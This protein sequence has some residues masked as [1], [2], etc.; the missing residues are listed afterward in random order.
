[1]TFY[2][3]HLVV[4]VILRIQCIIYDNVVSFCSQVK[5]LIILCCVTE[6][7]VDAIGV[8]IHS[9]CTRNQRN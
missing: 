3:P 8:T 5:K 2:R 4:V 9:E 6:D 7:T 1:V